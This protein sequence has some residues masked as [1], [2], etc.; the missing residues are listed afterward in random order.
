[1]DNHDV[2]SRIVGLSDDEIAQARSRQHH[3]Q[4]PIGV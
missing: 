1:M 4:P 2:L 3:R